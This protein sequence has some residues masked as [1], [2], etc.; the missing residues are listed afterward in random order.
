MTSLA[1]ASPES[2]N[3]RRGI[4][5]MLVTTIFFVSLDAT[6]KYLTR[7][8]PAIEIVWGRYL[9]H[10]IYAVIW[11]G[12]RLPSVMSHARYGMQF[13]RGLFLVLTTAIYFVA[14]RTM[15]LAAGTSIMFLSPIL[16][17]ALSVPLLREQ[18]GIRRWIGV[19]VGFAGA[20]IIVRPGVGVIQTS[21]LLAVLAAAIN[22]LY[23][24][25]TRVLART[26]RPMTTN[27]MSAFVG[28]IAATIGLPFVWVTPD[29]EGWAL[30]A[31]AGLCGVI[32]HYCMIRSLAEAPAAAVAPFTYVGLIWSTGYGF[33]LWGDLPDF[34]TIVGALVIIA[35]GLYIFYREQTK[36]RAPAG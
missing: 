25:T 6:A 5:W 10:T 18:V 31:F 30:M 33:L 36:K 11:A 1:I 16:V 9:F 32:G 19:A 12:T 29:L 4:L 2:A 15:P 34:W 28:A 14:L 22:A 24:I 26:D 20:V 8:L 13:L 23:Q 21:A 27:T 17:T 3:V 35:S 7:S